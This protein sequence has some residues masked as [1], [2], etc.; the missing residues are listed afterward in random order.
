MKQLRKLRRRWREEHPFLMDLI[1]SFIVAGTVVFITT[2]WFLYP[3]HVEGTSMYLTL[4]DL[5]I[6]FSN[7]FSYRTE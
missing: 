1:E 4:H 5:D 6:G 3:V 7:L 2:T